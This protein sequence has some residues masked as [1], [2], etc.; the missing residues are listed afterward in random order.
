MKLLRRGAAALV[1]VTA[2]AGL[3]LPTH[4]TAADPVGLPANCVADAVQV[5]CTFEFTGAVQTWTVPDGVTAATFE[6]L[7]AQ[8]GASPPDF[9]GNGGLG[10][11][12][13]AT[14]GVTPGTNYHLVVGGAGGTGTI[15][16]PAARGF[17]G[18]GSAGCAAGGGGGASDVRFGGT[19][20]DDRII[21]AGGGGGAGGGAVAHGGTGGGLNGGDGSRDPNGWPDGGRGGTQT[22]GGA[23]SPAGAFGVG[24]DGPI[25]GE[26]DPDILC[27]GDGGGGG[28]GGGYYGGGAGGVGDDFTGAGGG[29]GSGF[30]PDGVTFAN[31]VRSGNGLI[32][33]IYAAS[34]FPPPDTGSLKITKSTSNPDGATLPS[35]FT[36]TYDCGTGYTGTWSVANGASQT[37]TGI[38]TGSTCSVVETAP[39]AISGYTWATPTYTPATIVV[40]TKDGTFEI[41]VANSITRDRGSLTI[42]KKVV[43][44]N[45]GTATVSAF[46]LNTNAGSL[47]FDNGVPTG[48][49]TTY[50]SQKITVVTANYTLKENDVYGYTEGTWSCTDGTPNPT[51]YNN[52]SVNVDKDKDVVCTITNNDDPGKIVVI[53]NAKPAQGSFAFTT[54]GTGYNGF[55]LTG[56]T[57]N[58]GNVNT[59]TLNAGTY[60]VK[61]GTQLAWYLTGIG[62]STDPNTPYNCVVTGTGGSTGVGDLNTM[63]ATVNLKNGDTVT[64]TFE[65]T[66][67]GAT[68]TQGF[69]ATHSQLAQLAWFGGTGHGHTF[70]GVAATTGIG[71]TA[72]C[73]R[74]I[75]TLGKLMGGFWSDISKKSTGAKRSSLDQAR[76][77]LLQQL[78]AAELNASAFGSVPIGGSGMF[79]A[80]EAAYCGTNQTAIQKAQAQV[81]A[82][83]SAGDSTT[84]T[85]GGSADSKNARA[86]A[87]YLW[88]DTLP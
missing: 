33:V 35:A 71:D 81:S 82:F 30:G 34:T 7:G 36:G 70:P 84:F 88:W 13:L 52:G 45:G 48:T 58:N 31:G 16:G 68:R 83:N 1:V 87:N 8:G 76:M 74:P 17:N 42:V 64:C 65:N 28:G 54:T 66:G 19:S 15:P 53:K 9:G 79:A 77:R 41:V 73:G 47:T 44:D 63:T 49:T 14:V 43:N 23:G 24:A 56:A 26:A 86:V 80:W 5:T 11:R 25:G 12:A 51:T 72:R 32:R 27:V 20:L 75:D 2:G 61:E 38:P 29:G 4:P 10:G 62:G 6:V 21:V 18:G 40:S 55:T 37:I 57:T 78:L 59:Q 3:V 85:P 39:A 50:T 46:G 69:W 60:T 67:V 22:A